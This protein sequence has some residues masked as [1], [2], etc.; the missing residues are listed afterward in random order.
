MDP[1]MYAIRTK[2]L[3]SLLVQRGK[4]NRRFYINTEQNVESS[5]V[6]FFCF[7]R[8]NRIQLNYENKPFRRR[9]S[10]N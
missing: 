4:G 10:W 7:N 6:F 8:Q 1:S 9:F 5:F 3:F 2:Y